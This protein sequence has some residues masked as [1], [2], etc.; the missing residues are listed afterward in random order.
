MSEIKFL[1]FS[2]LHYKKMMYATK[3]S[4]LEKIMERA[5]SENAE[6]VI[7]EGDFCNDYSRSPEILNVYL[8]SGIGVFGVYG[9][10]E[11]ET[12]G[13]TMQM[14]TPCLTNAP[15]NIIWGTEDGKIGDGSIAYYYFDKEDSR[16]GC[17]QKKQ[18]I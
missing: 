1:F 4:D 6:F 16:C 13:N 9:N 17:Q 5:K 14:V 3:V 7:H 18:V 2:D 15:E 12:A 8:N 10:H 11:L